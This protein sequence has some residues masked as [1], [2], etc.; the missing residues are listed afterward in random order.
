MVFHTPQKR[1]N[2]LTLNINKEYPNLISLEYGFHFEMV[3]TNRLNDKD[4]LF[5][6][7]ITNS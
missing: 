1:V 4:T 5:Q 6:F 7:N 3:K 2:Y